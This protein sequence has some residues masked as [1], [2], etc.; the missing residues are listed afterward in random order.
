MA[1][2]LFSGL[3]KFSPD[4]HVIPDLAVSIPTIS[5]G[6]LVYTFTIRQDA[7]FADGHQCRAADV[8]FS[9][10]RALYKSTRSP[11][12]HLYLGNIRGARDV[13]RATRTS[14]TGVDVIDDLTLQIHLEH[15]DATF[16]QKL[17]FPV[18]AI[19]EQQSGRTSLVGAGPWMQ[20]DR[21][22][23]GSVTLTPAPH[24]YGGALDIRALTLVPARDDSVALA[25][26]RKGTVDIAHVA[27][28]GW[29]ALRSRDDFHAH[30]SLD[31][32]WVI[33]TRTGAPWLASALNR[34]T[35]LTHL[36]AYGLSSSNSI[37]PPSVPDYE[38]AP[39]AMDPLPSATQGTSD[40]HLF[41]PA[42]HDM[43]LQRLAR[44]LSR[45]WHTGP[46]GVP[47]ELVHVWRVLPDPLAWL[48]LVL[49]HTRSTWF[50]TLLQTSS[51]LTNDPVGRMSRYSTA[52]TW[53]LQEGLVIPLATGSTGY[54]IKPRVQG[55]QVS[56]L[57]LVPA[58]NSWTSV[59]VL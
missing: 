54:L 42:P 18:A 34:D 39:P 2:L 55:L 45:Q 23:D 40:V 10:A 32:Y 37:V 9:L 7:L 36:D 25:M 8:A 15:P 12:A 43:L 57:G 21:S 24:Y 27:P 20:R 19:V 35:L 1:S 29:D 41:T 48:R 14:L 16:L 53:A 31:A 26:Y 59:S 11:M 6:G 49:P 3:M 52:E 51:S 38:S 33:P 5:S 58:N 44:S 46:H 22:R 4:L 30:A 56:P 17:A 50:R 28:D 47:V 13:E